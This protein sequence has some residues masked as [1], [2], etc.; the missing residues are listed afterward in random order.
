MN[1]ITM[2]AGAFVVIYLLTVVAVLFTIREQGTDYGDVIYSLGTIRT[3]L[4][5]ISV[6]WLIFA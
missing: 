5:L 3:V 6:G 1:V 4:F 2:F